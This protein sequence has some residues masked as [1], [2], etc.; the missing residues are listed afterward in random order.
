VDAA[1]AVRQWVT[2]LLASLPLAAPTAAGGSERLSSA[3]IVSKVSSKVLAEWSS[4]DRS[5][6]RL[7]AWLTDNPKRSKQATL[8]IAEYLKRSRRL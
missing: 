1:S 7:Q 3:D 8:L 2:A 4:K 6:V 5:G